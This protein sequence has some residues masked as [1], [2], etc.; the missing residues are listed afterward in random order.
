MGIE[1]Q[2]RVKLYLDHDISYHLAE[3]LRIRGYDAIGAWGVGNACLSDSEQLEYATSQ[4]RVLVTCNAQDFA[5]IPVLADSPPSIPPKGGGSWTVLPRW[6]ELE[7]GSRVISGITEDFVPIYLGWWNEGRH[8]SGVVT[9]QQL[10]F[11]EMLRRLG[12]LLQSVTAKEMHD[13]IR[14]LAE[15]KER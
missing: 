5:A 13:A 9:S 11:G 10:P 8:H 6:G 14:N 12:N 7:G 1:P 2:Q 15:F 4:G 3:Q